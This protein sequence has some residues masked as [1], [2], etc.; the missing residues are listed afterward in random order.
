MPTATGRPDPAGPVGMKWGQGR[1]TTG[2]TDRYRTPAILL[3]WATALLIL[4]MIPAGFLM[5][6]Q[7]LPRPIQNSLF[8]FH[9]NFG[10]L[11]GMLVLVRLVWRLRNPPPPLPASVPPLQ[12]RI[13]DASHVLLYAAMVVMPVSGYVRVRAGG[14]PIEALDRLGI[15]SMIPRSDALAEAAK[16]V[17]WIAALLLSALVA[18]HVGAALHHLVVKRDG[19]FQRML[20]GR[21]AR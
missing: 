21:R 17:H 6:Q 5:I 19:V 4:A 7:G 1:M 16:S 10:V 20:P 14:F 18:A 12:R 9:K 15:T 8:I 11:V 2:T 13:A 3:H